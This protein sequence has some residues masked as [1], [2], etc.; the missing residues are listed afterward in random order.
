LTDVGLPGMNGKEL[1]DRLRSQLPELP[2]LLT[3][4]YTDRSV[5]DWG[6]LP[7]GMVFLPK[8]YDME[9]L[10]LKVRTLLERRT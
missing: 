6:V 4:G 3:S 9:A 1:A 10:V 7:L 8:P 5:M 2:V